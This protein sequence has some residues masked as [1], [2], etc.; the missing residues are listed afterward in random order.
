MPTS[1]ATP[2][3]QYMSRPLQ[4]ENARN[5]NMT[6]TIPS[7]VFRRPWPV[8]PAAD[9]LP[10]TRIVLEGLDPLSE[11][12]HLAGSGEPEGPGE[13]VGSAADP[14]RRF[15]QPDQAVRHSVADQQAEQTRMGEQ[16]L[17]AFFKDH[18]RIPVPAGKPRT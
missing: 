2:F 15:E 13:A 17:G 11:I 7:T 12:L 3:T 4:G 1:F 10:A 8:H 6:V 9:L 5:S 16:A 14:A 18:A